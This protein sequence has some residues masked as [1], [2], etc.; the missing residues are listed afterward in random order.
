MFTS[1][2][3]VLNVRWYA[4]MKSHINCS[5]M[6]VPLQELPPVKQLRP[7][8]NTN[9][10]ASF[11]IVTAGFC[12]R[13][14]FEGSIEITPLRFQS[15]HDPEVQDAGFLRS[16]FGREWKFHSPNFGDQV[17]GGAMLVEKIA[18]KQTDIHKHG[19]AFNFTDLVLNS[20]LLDLFFFF[21]LR[22]HDGSNR[23]Q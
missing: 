17:I 23:D 21:C 14:E 8:T 6:L 7:I 1:R 18:P 2:G 12:L 16:L 5:I 22:R 3:Q 13:N 15:C 11:G 19:P 9:G 4:W 20:H 10:E